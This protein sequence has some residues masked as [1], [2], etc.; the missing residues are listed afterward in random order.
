MRF[1]SSA[2]RVREPLERVE[3][4]AANGVGLGEGA[5]EQPV[6]LV[7]EPEV[8]DPPVELRCLARDQA[9][10]LGPRAE[11]GDGVA[12]DLLRRQAEGEGAAFAVPEEA[13]QLRPERRDPTMRWSGT[14]ATARTYI[15]FV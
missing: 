2:E 12:L 15:V 6:A 9:G 14:L 4:L 8:D 7:R 11:L 3:E 5:L 10:L 1:S 13:P